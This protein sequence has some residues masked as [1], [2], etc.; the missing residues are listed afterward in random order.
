M[1]EQVNLRGG[2]LE[3][4]LVSRIA[5]LETKRTYEQTRVQLIST[6]GNLAATR[7][8]LR[9]EEFG[10]EELD[11]TLINDALSERSDGHCRTRRNGE[12]HSQAYGPG[13]PA[14]GLC[15]CSRYRSGPARQNHRRSHR[16][17]RPDRPKW[18]PWMM[19]L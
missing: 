10:L 18:C 7:E 13:K 14:D 9:E 11:A 17:R 8:S 1:L 12:R 16:T 5:Y 15:A 2:L 19:S 6:A 4:G 3:K